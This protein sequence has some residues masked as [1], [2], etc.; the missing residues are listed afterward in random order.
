[1]DYGKRRVTLD[2]TNGERSWLRTYF[3]L[4]SVM[5]K[6]RGRTNGPEFSFTG[7]SFFLE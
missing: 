1:V 3:G 2:R 6:S 7:T 4:L 5:S